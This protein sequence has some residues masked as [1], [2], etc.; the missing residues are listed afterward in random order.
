VIWFINVGVPLQ[1]PF[2]LS[3]LFPGVP[4]AC[5]G[6]LT[7]LSLFSVLD[8]TGSSGF[9]TFSVP[10]PNDRLFNDLVLSSQAFCF[11]FFS[12]GGVVVSNGDQVQVGINPAMTALYNQ[13]SATAATGSIWQN[14]G[15][16]TLFEHN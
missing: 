13:G 8:T 7:P 6:Q 15:A 5:A 12:P 14:F 4:A 2:P 9:R 11:D 1:A 3:P 10:I 16:V